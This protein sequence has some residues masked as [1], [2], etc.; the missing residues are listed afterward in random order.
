[1]FSK[2]RLISVWFTLAPFMVL[3]VTLNLT[4]PAQAARVD[5][6]CNNTTSDSAT[7]QNVINMP[8]TPRLLATKSYSPSSV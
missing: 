5:V 8:S 4:R 2:T 3:G 1:M 6:A 7:I